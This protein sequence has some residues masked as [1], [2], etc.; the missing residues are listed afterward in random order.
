MRVIWKSTSYE[1]I[2]YDLIF[3]V[4][5]TIGGNDWRTYGVLFELEGKRHSGP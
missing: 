2:G 3:A 1:V 4:T 5:D